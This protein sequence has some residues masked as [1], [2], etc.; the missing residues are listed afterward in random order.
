[1]QISTTVRYY[2]FILTELVGLVGFTLPVDAQ[3][4]FKTAIIELQ[5]K[6]AAIA[7]TQFYIFRVDDERSDLRTIGKVVQVN[8]LKPRQPQILPAHL[9]GGGTALRSFIAASIPVNKN[10]RPLVIKIKSVE[11][12]ERPVAANRAEGK[13]ALSLQFGLLRNGEFV[14]LDDYTA[15]SSYQRKS[16]AAQK[17]EPLLS[18]MMVKGLIYINNW[19]NAQADHHMAL[20]KKVKISFTDHKNTIEDDTVYYDP[21]RPLKWTDFAGKPHNSK[22]AAEIFAALGYDEDVK[23]SNAIIDIVLD[24]KVYVPKSA[25][26]VRSGGLNSNSL[27]HEQLHFD[28]VKLVAERFKQRLARTE[29]SVDNYDGPIN[30]AYLDALREINE[31]QKRYDSETS[32]GLE[33]YQQQLWT[34]RVR[35]ELQKLSVTQ[36]NTQA[37]ELK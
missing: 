12:D 14:K 2:L 34:V 28:I 17:A 25:C 26:W 32:H 11:I 20:A 6:P 7:P 13:I 16:G 10:L 23:L 27:A 8:D 5:P 33:G 36:L 30:M 31:I 35:Q 1:M 4:P 24:I 15:S 9:G 29:L 37:A 21:N 18:N 3:I 22:Y 19:V